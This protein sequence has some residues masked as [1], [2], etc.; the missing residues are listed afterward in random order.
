MDRYVGIPYADKGRDP[1]IGLDCWGLVR[2]FYA[3]EFGL[4]LPAHDERYE[5]S[6]ARAEV[7]ALAQAETAAHWR[8]VPVPA[9][10]DV[11]VITV[12]RRPFH[13][14]IALHDD[15]FLH[16][17]TAPQGAVIESLRSPKWAPRIEGYYRHV[18]RC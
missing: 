6:Y 5:H 9:Y 12:A 18:A 15:R 7:A 8:P 13:V 10:G 4:H 3:E 1:A 14:G 11:V 17:L 16:N 2:W